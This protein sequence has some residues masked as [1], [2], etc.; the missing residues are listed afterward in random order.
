MTLMFDGASE[1][2]DRVTTNV[3]DAT[4]IATGA[5]R[6]KVRVNQV[7]AGPIPWDS[8]LPSEARGRRPRHSSAPVM[9]VR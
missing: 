4:Y 2:P 9:L 3:G 6:Q 7:A 1:A 5:A 8:E